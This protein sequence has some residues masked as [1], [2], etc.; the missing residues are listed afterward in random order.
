A[1][2]VKQPTVADKTHTSEAPQTPIVKPITT[3]FSDMT[4]QSP[5][6]EAVQYVFDKGIMNG[7]SA[8]SFAP[9]VVSSRAMIVTLL[10]RLEGE[11]E[12]QSAGFS[13]VPAKKYYAGAVAW[14]SENGVVTGNVDGTFRPDD[15][16]TWE[17]LVAILYRYAGTKEYDLT[18][19][20]DLGDSKISKYAQEP[21]A[22]A[23]AQGLL[24]P[25][26][27][28]NAKTQVTRAEI[29]ETLMRFCENVATMPEAEAS[30][31]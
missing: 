18:L 11:P 30:V 23:L 14:A 20:A 26:Q 6:Y 28:G 16:V 7:V 9:E 19:R 17:Q 4:A 29:A 21:M 3:V 12:A 24:D 8:T 25:N 13:D 10:Y 27:L 22:W 15:G 31:G 5:H 1:A 2:P